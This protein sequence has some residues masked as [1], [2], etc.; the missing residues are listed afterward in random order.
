MRGIQSNLSGL[1]QRQ[2]LVE[3]LL[4]KART[5][6]EGAGAAAS[7]AR[8]PL[9]RVTG[10]GSNPG[11][12]GMLT[13]VPER[14]APSPAL[15]VVLHGCTQSPEGYNDGSGWSDLA[16]RH[17]FVLL[18]PEQTRANNPKSCFSWFLPDDTA[19]GSGEALSIRQMIERAVEDHGIDRSRIFVTG[20]SAGGAMAAAML[21]A[22]PEVFAAGA[23]I[24]G[25]PYGAAKNVQEALESMFQ[26]RPRSAREW[27]DLVRSA[28]SH[29]GEW[30]RVSIWHGATDHV[31]KPG[32]ATELVKQ[33]TDVHGLPATPSERGLVAGHSRE[34]WHDASGTEIVES[35]AIVGM[36]HGTPLATGEGEM[37][38]GMAGAFMLD[39]GISSSHHIARFFGL[40]AE[41]FESVPASRE[42]VARPKASTRPGGLEGEILPPPR[43]EQKP[44]GADAHPEMPFGVPR[45]LPPQVLRVIR[46][47]FEAAGL[48]KR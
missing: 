27:G 29:R 34:V 11:N 23:I 21:A 25:L 36:G 6:V 47:A 33:W 39:V 48:V 24:A 44:E 15:V 5:T 13:Y 17:G 4:R 35:F 28:S 10:F 38:G 18:F 45:T 20:L 2:K 14:L 32:N 31:V 16:D 40:T 30:P 43:R 19:R 22:Y 37:E 1:R 3:E 9:T 12:L 26:G 7:P 42:A 41:V 46:D 8:T